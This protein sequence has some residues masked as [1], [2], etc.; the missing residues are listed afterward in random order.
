MSKN[1]DALRCVES[2]IESARPILAEAAAAKVEAR[3][4]CTAFSPAIHADALSQAAYTDAEQRWYAADQ[5]EAE[6]KAKMAA[7]T[8][9]QRRLSAELE[10]DH[11]AREAQRS[12]SDLNHELKQVETTLIGQ[13]AER[14]KAQVAWAQASREWDE[15]SGGLRPDVAAMQRASESRNQAIE[16]DRVALA[17]IQATE[18]RRDALLVLIDR[19]ERAYSAPIPTPLPPLPDSSLPTE[20]RLQALEVLARRLQ[21]RRQRLDDEYRRACRGISEMDDALA[22]SGVPIAVRRARAAEA[23]FARCVV[24]NDLDACVALLRCVRHDIAALEQ[25]DAVLV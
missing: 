4:R 13:R 16:A 14:R 10:Q 19:R 3:A 15:A 21:R 12:T 11:Q 8:M 22:A 1:E 20:D 24:G 6:A 17:S 18:A 7:L 25:L 23:L 2:Q 9:E 5:A